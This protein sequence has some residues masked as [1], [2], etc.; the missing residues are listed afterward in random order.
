MTLFFVC[1]FVFLC[2]H[3]GAVYCQLI[4]Q[5]FPGSLE[6][7]QVR[8]CN[9]SEAASMQNFKLLQSVFNNLGI[10]RVSLF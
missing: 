6:V 3:V 7:T 4:H 5:L 10:K 8:P 9:R 2:A 1:V